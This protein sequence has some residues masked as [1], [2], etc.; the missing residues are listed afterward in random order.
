MIRSFHALISVQPGFT[1]PDQ[2]QLA[3]ISIPDAEAR[4]AERVIRMQNEIL[5]KVAALP[6][7]DSAAFATAVPTEEPQPRNPVFVEGQT[8][9]DQI[10]PIR[11]AKSVSPGY[12]K[13][14]GT[15]LIAGRDFTWTD[16]Y[17]KRPVTVV[18][19]KMARETW[20]AV[21]GALGRRIRIGNIGEWR[22]V[23]GVVGN[24]HDEGVERE[25]SGAV[26]WRA[27]VQ[28][29]LMGAP[30]SAPRSVVFFIRSD[31]AGSESLIADIR[32]AV[33][34]VDSNLPLAQVRTLADV[35]DRSVARTSFTLVMLG[36]AA[37]IALVLG[38][39]GIYGVMAYSVAQRRR[40]IGV[41][42]ALGAQPASLK[43][44]FVR[45]GLLLASIGVAIGLGAAVL[46][47]RVMSS[48]LFGVRPLDPL[49]FAAVAAL[50][51]IAA[52]SASYLPAR[53]ASS[54]DPVEVLKA[55]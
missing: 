17:E 7:V 26:Y 29:G 45:Q 4:D 33:W 11:V 31:R 41:R 40:E 51:S 5:D 22:E 28:P 23:V 52:A 54:V 43:R 44:G 37:S 8:P 2:I 39:V 42:L 19:E 9:N 3:R 13:A 25:A 38:V 20:G 49:T 55:D 18:S 15:P 53:R 1:R 12:F 46:L 16:I 36:I 30:A 47:T 21:P 34:S 24:V 6:G 32:Q 48:L 27:G 10:G 35:Y 50:V 14:Q